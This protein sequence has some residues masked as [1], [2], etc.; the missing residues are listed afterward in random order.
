M[1]HSTIRDELAKTKVFKMNISNHCFSH[2]GNFLYIVRLV[3]LFTHVNILIVFS[4]RFLKSFYVSKYAGSVYLQCFRDFFH[5][6][7]TTRV[8]CEYSCYIKC[9]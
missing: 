1:E 2:I 6:S 4:N 3:Q 7:K 8:I 9:K 5:F